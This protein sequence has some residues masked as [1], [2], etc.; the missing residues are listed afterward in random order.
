M[1]VRY[2]TNWREFCDMNYE[3]Y[4]VGIGTSED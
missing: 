3:P 4:P 1:R 2:A